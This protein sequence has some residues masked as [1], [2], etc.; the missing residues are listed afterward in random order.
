M[1]YAQNIAFEL[2]NESKRNGWICGIP[3]KTLVPGFMTGLSGIAYGLLRVCDPV[4]VPN[5]LAFELP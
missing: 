3:Q 5:V 2:I 1:Q 4:N